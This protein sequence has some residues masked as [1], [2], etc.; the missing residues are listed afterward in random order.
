MRHTIRPED[1]D[2]REE[3]NELITTDGKRREAAQNPRLQVHQVSAHSHFARE[4][5]ITMDTMIHGAAK[6]DSP[7][8]LSRT[9][10]FWSTS[11]RQ[12]VNRS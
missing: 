4:T 2:A 12:S 11:L 10:Y 9:S 5:W 3:K 8:V 7:A 1:D 6:L